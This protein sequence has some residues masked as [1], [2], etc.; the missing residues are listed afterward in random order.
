MYPL[1]GDS[2]AVS[3]RQKR[4]DRDCHSPDP[5]VRSRTSQSSR[6]HE[7]LK[8]KHQE[9]EIILRAKEKD[10]KAADSQLKQAE[11]SKNKVQ[12]YNA[13]VAYITQKHFYCVYN[14]F[15]MS[16]Q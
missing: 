6:E 12:A 11:S 5:F 9:Q 2:A 7:E 8:M 10:L 13:C 15:T 3:G 4:K 16:R 1:E 14:M